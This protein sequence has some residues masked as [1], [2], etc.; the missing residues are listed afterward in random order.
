MKRLEVGTD[1]TGTGRDEIIDLKSS[2]FSSL[3]MILVG[4]S[5]GC[6]RYSRAACLVEV[7]KIP[8]FGYLLSG[9]RVRVRL[10]SIS[11]RRLATKMVQST[12]VSIDDV[13]VSTKS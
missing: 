13:F 3:P 5:T 9:L 1:F 7:I 8:L 12:R 11:L 6:V 4:A 10:D 2:I